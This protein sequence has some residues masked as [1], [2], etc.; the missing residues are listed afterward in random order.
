MR[1]NVQR[2]HAEKADTLATH[3][4]SMVTSD[5]YILPDLLNRV[6]PDTLTQVSITYDCLLNA[7][8]ETKVTSRTGLDG[9]NPIYVKNLKTL[10]R[11]PLNLLF[12]A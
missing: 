11:R 9:I 6:S 8:N 4:S 2:R 3:Q 10:L 12:Q 1:E 5:N 7:S